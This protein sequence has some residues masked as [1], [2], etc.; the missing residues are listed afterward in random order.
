MNTVLIQEATRFNALIKVVRSSL[1]NI[2]EAIAGLQVMSAQLEVA[3]RQIYDGKIPDLWLKSSYPSLKP[4]AGYVS[5]LLERIAFLQ[6]WIDEGMP[7]VY[8]LSGFYFTQSFLTGVLQN[9]ARKYTIPIDL[10]EFQF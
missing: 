6:K 3:S 4:L 8:W 10:I 1:F 2:R 9:F 7:V 5:N